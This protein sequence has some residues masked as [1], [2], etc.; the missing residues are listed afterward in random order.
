[1]YQR[2]ISSRLLDALRRAPVVVLNGARQTGKSTLARA[3]AEG[4]HPAE[5]LT[6]DDAA[7][8]A[9]A[10]SDPQGFIQGLRGPVVLDEAQRAPALFRAV[11]LEVDQSRVPGR[12]LLT[13]SANVLTLPVLSESLA[14]RSELLT[15]WPLSQGELEGTLE[16]FIDQCFEGGFP[17]SSAQ[18][19]SRTKLA[20][21]VATGGFPEVIGKDASG[22]A[23][24]YGSYITTILQRDVREL[25]NIDG[26]TEMPRLLALLASRVGALLN[27][28]EVSRSSGISQTTLRRYLA[29]LET[30]FLFAALPAW[31]TNLG[32][33]LVKAP[34]AFL[35]DTGLAAYLT[36]RDENRLA[37]DPSAF[38][39]LLENFVVMELRKQA[40][41]AVNRVSLFHFRT[42]VGQE[43]DVV[44]ERPDGDIVGIEIKASATIEPRD[45]N[46][47][48]A[49][50]EIAGKRFRGGILLYTGQK[51]VPF[52]SGI[53][54][55]PLSRLW[56]KK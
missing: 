36:G 14:G 7:V 46:G 30:T 11:K 32:K 27:L 44:I 12:F 20:S 56:G 18:T 2:N 47:F 16:N 13:G 10:N 31:S 29:L 42:Q 9:A 25:A 53:Q 19:D 28:A 55:V 51:T 38:G 39:A 45:M 52:G 3:F 6:L 40:G 21:R 33:R 35:T 54:A 37:G 1:M 24:W 8:F 43:V 23:A 41:W 4:A 34:K 15:L 5:Y 22:R 48:K 49:L 17:P 50:A 26:L